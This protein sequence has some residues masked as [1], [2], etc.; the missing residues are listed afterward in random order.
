MINPIEIAEAFRSLTAA[1][2]NQ[3]MSLLERNT[4]STD[5]VMLIAA[6]MLTENW[7]KN[8][9]AITP[10]APRPPRRKTSE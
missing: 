2:R 4:I 1:Q 3:I 10:P 8:S 5:A 6:L 7:N 9:V